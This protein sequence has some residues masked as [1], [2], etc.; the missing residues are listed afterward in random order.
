[1]VC[2][3]SSVLLDGTII[4]GH[5]GKVNGSRATFTICLQDWELY[6]FLF[7]KR[8]KYIVVLHVDGEGTTWYYLA[9]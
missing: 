2:V 3:S 9:C 1:M 8:S 5:S 4:Q 7:I 6:G